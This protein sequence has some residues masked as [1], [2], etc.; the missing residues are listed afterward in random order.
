L[1][2]ASK[3]F[4]CVRV[5]VRISACSLRKDLLEFVVKEFFDVYILISIMFVTC[6]ESHLDS[7]F[8]G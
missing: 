1:L 4:V 3:V 6:K 2:K 7:N 8:V 5:R